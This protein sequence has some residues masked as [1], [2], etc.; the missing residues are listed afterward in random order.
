M[1]CAAGQDSSIN[2]EKIKLFPGA[3]GANILRV[4]K[5]TRK[6]KMPRKTAASLNM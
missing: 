5:I 6:Q 1:K 3:A 2:R 4:M